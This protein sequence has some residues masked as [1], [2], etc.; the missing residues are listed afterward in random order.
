MKSAL[1]ICVWVASVAAQFQFP[2]FAQESAP[3]AAPFVERLEFEISDT[4]NLPPVSPHRLWLIELYSGQ[5]QII[6]G[7]TGDTLGSMYSASL[8]NFA[9]GPAHSNVYI[10]E[11]VWSK[12]NRGARQDLLAVYDGT[13]LKLLSEITLPG[14]IYMAPL[15]PNFVVTASGARAYVYNMQ[16]A[17]S[18]VIV[19]L[20][21]RKVLKTVDTPG[22]ALVYPSADDSFSSLCANG[23]LATVSNLRHAPAV[24]RSEPFFD[25]Q[26]DPV[27]E[28]SPN[29]PA[30]GNTLFVTY[31]GVVHPV[32]LGVTPTF[33]DAWSLTESARLVR[34]SLSTG[35]LAWRPGGDLPVAVHRA[36]GSMFVLMHAGETWS[37]KKP[38]TELWVVD[39]AS[40]QTIRRMA[41]ET[42]VSAV[43][44][45]QDTKPLLYLIDTK[46]TL[47]ILDAVTLK[48]LQTIENVRNVVPYVPAS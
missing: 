43:S 16:P 34:A 28:E 7:D 39:I 21:T 44:V 29:D 14:R 26:N 33:S 35:D 15:S 2:L 1:R 5:L 41:L 40:R 18:V 48:E 38:G 46:Q 27:F 12:G 10:A 3:T 13:T 24:V 37:H 25:A 45:S 4:A 31:S 11:T 6:D 20:K 36:T 47:R 9:S 42:P 8:S 22:C 23:S 19:D 32:R 30:T 17:S